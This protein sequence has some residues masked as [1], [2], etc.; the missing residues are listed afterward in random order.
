M[1]EEQELLTTTKAEGSRLK[2]SRNPEEHN[3]ISRDSEE[4]L[5]LAIADTIR[6]LLESL[7]AFEQRH[8]QRPFR[9]S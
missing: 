4:K 1:S 5:L 8:V 6:G 2:T 3:L 7:K 9:S